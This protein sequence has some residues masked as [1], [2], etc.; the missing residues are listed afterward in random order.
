VYIEDRSAKG[1]TGVQLVLES[2]IADLLFASDAGYIVGT[3]T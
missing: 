2:I 1:F 3:L